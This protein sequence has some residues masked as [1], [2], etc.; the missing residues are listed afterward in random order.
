MPRPQAFEEPLDAREFQRDDQT[1][2]F[3]D[4]TFIPLSGHLCLSHIYSLGIHSLP[5][6]TASLFS[7]R[8][9]SVPFA[10]PEFLYSFQMKEQ[11]WRIPELLI[12]LSFVVFFFF[13]C[14]NS[15]ASKSTKS[16][17]LILLYY[18]AKRQQPEERTKIQEREKER[19]N[20]LVWKEYGNKYR[21][22]RKE[23]KSVEI[24]R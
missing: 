1:S 16:G 4:S 20:S 12:C 15:P 6:F 24:S 8:H 18:T 2:D 22:P 21:L 17:G 11:F 13:T 23:I 5:A 3:T 10:H 9:Y 14:S 19:W 7:H